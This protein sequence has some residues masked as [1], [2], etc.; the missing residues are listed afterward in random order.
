MSA[1]SAANEDSHGHHDT[2]AEP[3]TVLLVDD[4]DI[5][6]R[7]V[8]AALRADGIGP[9]DTCSNAREVVATVTRGRYDLIFLDL[10]M[11]HRNGDEILAELREQHPDLPIVMLTAAQDAATAVNCMRLGAT[12]YLVKPVERSQIVA[13]AGQLMSM[14]QLERE[15]DRLRQNF[16]AHGIRHPEHFHDLITADDA[17]RLLFQ[18]IE[19]ISDSDQPVL[20]TGE[21]GTGKELIARAIH[22][23]RG[24]HGPFVAVNTAGL[25]DTAFSSALFGHVKGAYTGAIE[26]R[27]GFIEQAAGGTLFLDEI[28]DLPET[29]QIKL[30]RLLQEHEYYPLG[31]DHSRQATCRLV[32]ATNRDINQ[33]QVFRRDL[34]Y[35]LQTHHIHL[36]PLRDRKRDIPL[37][38]D[39]FVRHSADQ[40]NQRV[41]RI[42]RELYALLAGYAF[43]GNVRELEGMVHDA[44]SQVRGGRLPLSPFRQRLDS[45]ATSDDDDSGVIQRRWDFS[46]WRT[47]PSLKQVQELLI[48]EALRR[49]DGNQGAAAH[50][51]GISRQAL[52]QR[53]NKKQ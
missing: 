31:S 16:L 47:L 6:L 14:R 42:P 39:H 17:M 37:L 12:N 34:Y 50:F 13:L 24:D 36:P 7:T 38:M 2:V 5:I 1:G 33:E 35:R 9:V 15:N 46:R 10:W 43:P 27:P 19:A 26:K 45:Q 41:P 28:G 40:L 18:Y 53:L 11:P 3:A 48:A 8:A 30:L 32:V 44:V 21:T 20:I 22:R 49:A 25:D 52:N 4:D 23:S 29:C 51:L